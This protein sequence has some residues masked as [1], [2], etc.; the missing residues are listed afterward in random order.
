MRG[1]IPRRERSR[2]SPENSRAE[3]VEFARRIALRLLDARSRSE[4]EL[5]D[6]LDS[7]G[8]PEDV[9]EEL[10]ERFHEVGLLDDAAFAEA[11]VQTRIQVD[12]HGF[13]RIRAELRRRGVD[14]D[15][16]AEALSRVGQEE[17]LVAARAFAQRRARALAGL[18]SRVARRRLA[19]ALGRRGFGGAVVSSVVDEVLGEMDPDTDG[20]PL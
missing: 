7:R 17:E 9:V 16:V 8:V 14:E 2:L 1:S 6:R 13:T 5:R 10:V 19:G 11:L 15:V 20:M 4:A 12:R 18:D 3:Q